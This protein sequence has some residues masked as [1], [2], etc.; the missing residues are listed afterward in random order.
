MA[1]AQVLTKKE[2]PDGLLKVYVRFSN[3][4]PT[5][6]MIDKYLS[7][8]EDVYNQKRKFIV[9]YDASDISIMIGPAQLYRQ[10]AFMQKKDAETREYLLRCAIVITSPFVK[11]LLDGVFALKSPACELKIFNN[12]I[13]AKAFLQKTEAVQ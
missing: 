10:V 5:N 2:E 4:S 13:D 12:V 9:L 8:I 6:E 11:A 1:F 7:E 3:Q